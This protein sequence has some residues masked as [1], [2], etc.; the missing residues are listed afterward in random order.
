ME[1]AVFEADDN[2]W[3][4]LYDALPQFARDVFYS[5]GFAQLCQATLDA[6]HQVRCAGYANNDGAVL[7]YPFVLRSMR[8]FVERPVA[9]NLYDSISLYGRGGVVGQASDSSL[10][11]FHNDLAAYMQRHR[12]LCSF[13]RLH[14][15]IGNERLLSPKSVVR[16]VGGFVVVDLR[17]GEA[18]IEASFKSSV[19]KD[20]RKAQRNGVKCF[21][22]S[23]CDHL[24]DFMEIYYQTMERN[25]ANEFYFFP[26]AFFASLPR[27][28]PGMFT[29]FYAT[30]GDRIV[31]CELV[32]HCADYSHSFLGGTRKEALPL[33]ANPILKFEIFKKMKTNGCQ[34]FLLGGGQAPNDGIFNFKKSYA[35]EGVYPS[36][37]GGTVWQPDAYESLKQEMLDSGLPVAANR[38]QFYDN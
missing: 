12:V 35:P 37:I 32:L 15:L 30:Y 5:P 19:R 34:Y 22:E 21:S 28:L 27:H 26:E 31:S 23:N 7:L 8:K 4:K 9:D 10:A 16:D 11:T 1:F 33:A 20:I 18:D 13:D 2:R 24:A 17:P 6:D 3:V 14:P 29:F 38:F 36:Y 25:S